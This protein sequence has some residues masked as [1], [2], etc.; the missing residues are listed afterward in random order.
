MC[1]DQLGGLEQ[2]ETTSASPL[3]V[4]FP[5]RLSAQYVAA[6]EV[7]AGRAIG[8]VEHIRAGNDVPFPAWTRYHDWMR[9]GAE[10]NGLWLRGDPRLR[11]PDVADRPGTGGGDRDGVEDGFHRRHSGRA[12]LPRLPRA[13]GVPREPL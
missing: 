3:V 8:T 4:S 7:I 1:W 6:H 12:A 13:A 2:A 9:G 11:R 10:T 5:M